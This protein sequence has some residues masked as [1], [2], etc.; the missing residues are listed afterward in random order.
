MSTPDSGAADI[1]LICFDVDGTL[2]GDTV[3]IW[4]TMHRAFGCDQTRRQQARDDFFAGRISY[5]DWFAHDIALLRERGADRTGIAKVIDRLTPAP[6]ARETLEVLRARGY[7]LAVISGSLSCVVERFFDL[8]V[9][10]HLLINRFHFDASGQLIG[11]EATP[12]DVD[13]KADGLRE[14]ARRE[15]IQASQCA[16]VGDNRNDL[17]AMAAAGLAI[18]VHP[19]HPD[20]IAAADLCMEGE[21]LRALLQHFPGRD[22]WR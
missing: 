9:F 21:D 20:V 14:L 1:A 7:R 12:Y 11:G 13:R 19:K 10:D 2:V 6:G 22:A 5:D 15:G 8:A 16:F 17:T 3:Y 18:A 4:E